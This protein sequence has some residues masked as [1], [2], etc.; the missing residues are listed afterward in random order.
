MASATGA[1]AKNPLEAVWEPK[2][3]LMYSNDWSQS[4]GNNHQGI[5]VR[6]SVHESANLSAHLYRPR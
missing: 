2:G 3:T 1:G 5:V 4:G 6:N